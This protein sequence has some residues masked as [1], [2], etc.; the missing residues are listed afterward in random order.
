LIAEPRAT[1]LFLSLLQAKVGASVVSRLG[2]L[3]PTGVLALPAREIA[4]RARLTEKGRRAFEELKEGF[5][6]EVIL[7]RLEERG[8]EV[9]TLAD[10]GYPLMLTEIPDPPPALFV[11]GEVPYA[12]TVALVGSR[13]ASA[14][15][16]EAARTLGRALGERGVCVASGLALGIDAAAHEGA[17][18]AGGPTIGVLGCGIDVVYPRS[19]RRL[20]GRVKD[21]GGILSEYYLGEAPLQWRFPARNRIIAGLSDVVV[22]VEAPEKSGALITARHAL[23]AG[24]DVWAVPGPFAFAECRGSNALL[25][26]GAG[27]L[28]DLD[29]FV[30]TVVPESTPQRLPVTQDATAGT[31]PA[32]VELPEKEAAALAGVGFEPTG[33]DVVAQRVAGSGVEM[34]ELLS[35]LALLELKGYVTRDAGGAFVR[36]PI[37]DSSGDPRGAL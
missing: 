35:A 18:E 5:E 6:P 21:G 30:D 26:D 28:W 33:V 37:G 25:S 22:V 13:K 27:V 34:R 11:D 14:T 20:F 4:E 17:L 36:N 32:P 24:R 16:I 23:E 9:V 2:D 1:Y 7:A 29:R 12:P 10:E 19:N 3:D 8:I 15:G 31:T